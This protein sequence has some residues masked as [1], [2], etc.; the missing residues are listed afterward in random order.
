MKSFSV[1]WGCVPF[2]LSLLTAYGFAHADTHY[3]STTGSDVPPH[4]SWETAA[5]SI[6]TAID[7]ASEGDTVLVGPGYFEENIVLKGGL[8]VEGSPS[9][10]TT[11]GA[12]YETAVIAVGVS[13]ASIERVTIAGPEQYGGRRHGRGIHIED[14]T[15]VAVRHCTIKGNDADGEGG[16]GIH[17][18]ESRLIIQDCVIEANECRVWKIRGTGAA[19][20]KA[21]PSGAS[22]AGIYAMGSE[23]VVENCVIKGNTAGSG[24]GGIFLACPGKVCSITGCEIIANEATEGSGGGIACYCL[25][26][27]TDCIIAANQAHGDG[28]GIWCGDT[29]RIQRCIICNNRAEVSFLT[30]GK[31]GGIYYRAG[32]AGA[33]I[34][35]VIAGNSSAA[36]QA[37]GVFWE[38]NANVVNCTIVYHSGETKGSTGLRV[39]YPAEIYGTYE[40]I[41]NCVFFGNYADLYRCR[42]TYSATRSQDEVEGE[43]N[44]Q[45]DPQL[46]VYATCEVESVG[47]YDDRQATTAIVCKETIGDDSLYRHM[48]VQRTP[49]GPT[50]L[51]A[52]H[53]GNELLCYGRVSQDLVGE[54]L[55]I[56]D[57]S[58]S[59]DSPCIDSGNSEAEYL[60]DE[61]KAGKFRIYRGKDEWRVDMGA[62]EYNSRRL[63]VSAVEPTADAGYMKITWNSQL[64]PGKTYSIYFSPDV[65]TWTLGGSKI[66]SRAESTS[67]VDPDAG[68]FAR[69]FYRISA[70]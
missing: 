67:W 10:A 64:L 54:T 55:E 37:D 60:P 41:T 6:Q 14:C 3:A 27:I 32:H 39:G 62:Y 51:I 59:E 61:D 20:G 49:Y 19:A 44:T 12:S 69:R 38:A 33:I 30:E 26:E 66:P 23:I 2:L 52:G 15:D 7:A 45:E 31:G 63:Q 29:M 43:G 35:C 22:G 48:F 13:R 46:R 1:R 18:V 70:P 57:F 40:N 28:G 8:A 11:I 56:T 42:A 53:S 24:G 25:G 50:S 47:S 17:A 5:R 34:N 36:R 9:G 4:T 58:L 21:E 65:L 68:A 16:P